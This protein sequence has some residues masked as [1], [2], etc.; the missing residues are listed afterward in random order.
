LSEHGVPLTV[1]QIP[2][3]YNSARAAISQDI[4]DGEL[5]SLSPG[6]SEMVLD[7]DTSAADPAHFSQQAP[8]V[9]CMMKNIDE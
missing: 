9:G 3:L 6:V 1:G 7:Y 4:E 8:E 5:L 2:S